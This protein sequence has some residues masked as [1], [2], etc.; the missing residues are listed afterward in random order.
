MGT[1]SGT[2]CTSDFVTERAGVGG[3]RVLL[4]EEDLIQPSPQSIFNERGFVT[5]RQTHSM[6]HN[7]EKKCLGKAGFE[8]GRGGR[9]P[10]GDGGYFW[11]K[12]REKNK[13]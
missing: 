6:R 10:L 9:N 4:F 2:T 11:G 12:M 8:N 1:L 5:L 3:E 13:I 7:L